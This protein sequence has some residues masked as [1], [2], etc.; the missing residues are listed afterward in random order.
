YKAQAGFRGNL[1]QPWSRLSTNASIRPRDRGL[2][3]L[4]KDQAGLCGKRFGVIRAQ[5]DRL[6]KVFD[7]PVVQALSV[8]SVAAAV[9]R[10]KAS[11]HLP[12]RTSIERSSSIH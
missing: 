7:C 9:E 12:S 5:L 10:R 2:R 1:L 11:T 8:V 6:I 3:S 4:Y